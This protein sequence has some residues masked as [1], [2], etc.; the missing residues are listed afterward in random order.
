VTATDTMSMEGQPEM[1]DNE[2]P[3][4]ADTEVLPAPPPIDPPTDPAATDPDAPFGRKAD[5]TPY[6]R[7]PSGYQ[8]RSARRAAKTGGK[9]TRAPR[10]GG[11][12][13]RSADFRSAVRTLFQLPAMILGMMPRRETRQ[14]AYVISA[15]VGP[16]ED[17][18]GNPVT[19]P[20]VEAINK[21]GQ[22]QP[23]VG[24]VLEQVAKIGPYGDLLAVGFPFV[25]QLGTVLG[26]IP[27][28]KARALGLMTPNR[29]E[30]EMLRADA[31]HEAMEAQALADEAAEL[32]AL[33]EQAAARNGH[34]PAAA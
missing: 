18:Q 21:L 28:S 3:A 13:A 16:E 17:E 24:A 26:V 9:K 34:Q 7:D 25:M 20:L 27:P 19:S 33:R 10:S 31:H 4:E 1:F 12:G 14:A 8:K 22:D 11:S 23:K 15:Y 6:K 2:D 30:I 32:Q 29:I 5:G